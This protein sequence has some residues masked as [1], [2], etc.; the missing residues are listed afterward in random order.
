MAEELKKWD[1][2]VQNF[3]S[4]WTGAKPE[5]IE[6]TLIEWGMDSWEVICQGYLAGK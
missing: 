4:T 5:D 2:R 6:A 1:Y 3:G